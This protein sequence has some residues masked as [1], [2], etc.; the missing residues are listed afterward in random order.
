MSTARQDERREDERH[1]LTEQQ[2]VNAGS[3]LGERDRRPSG[4][5]PV[6]TAEGRPAKPEPAERLVGAPGDDPAQQLEV[7]EG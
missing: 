5:P 6:H 2:G 1:D 3:S 4:D 7:G